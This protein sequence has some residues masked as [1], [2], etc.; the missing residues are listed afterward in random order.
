MPTLVTIAGPIASGKSTV[1]AFLAQRCSREGRTVVIADVDDVA[2]MVAEPG[3]AEAGLWFAAHEVHGALV[4]RWMLTEVNVVISV[5]P[6]YSEAE[7]SALFGPWPPGARPWRVLMMP[8]CRATWERVGVDEGRGLSRQ[9]DFHVAAHARFRAL[10][11]GIPFDLLFNSGDTSATDIA[12][13]VI[14]AINAPR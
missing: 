14:Q 11:P 10:M 13:L 9:R 4:A 1:A 7:Q 3:A 12:A 5:G 8:R 6:V 2:A